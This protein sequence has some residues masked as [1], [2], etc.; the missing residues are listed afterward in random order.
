[1][2]TSC[3][4]SP[5][6]GGRVLWKV[7]QYILRFTNSWKDS[8]NSEELLYPGSCLTTKDTDLVKNLPAN[9]GGIRDGGSI[10]GLGRSCG[11]R[12]CQTTLVFLSK[13]PPR[14][15]SLAGYSPHRVTKS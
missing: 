2:N 4:D 6:I 13:E 9:A 3:K 11:S 15:R 8:Q 10:P 5:S 14:Q 12:Y 7:P 1:M